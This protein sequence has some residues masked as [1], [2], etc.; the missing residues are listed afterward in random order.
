M[1]Y[2]N[3]SPSQLEAKAEELLKNF[4]KERLVKTKPIDVYAVIENCL[5]VPYDWKYLTPDQ[6]VLGMTAFNA[7]YIWVWDKPYYKDGMKPYQLML[8]KGTIV[9]DST[10]TEGN[11]RGRE[12]FTVMHEVF[13]Q[14]LHKQ[15]FRREPPDYIHETTNVAVN[16]KKKLVT[17][18]DKIEYQAN[19]CAAAF[20]MP[21]DL[22]TS[23]FKQMYSGSERMYS[24]QPLA[25]RIISDM[26]EEF[27][28]SNTAM[29][30]RLQNLSL[31]E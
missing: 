9:I 10:L 1:I 18:L 22:I 12:N 17:T 24:I 31:I 4:D 16:G 15:C 2:Y 20:L 21:R 25:K 8:E 19:T 28:V 13:H 23:V 29:K 7:G 5:D 30:Y 3:Y 11:N 14:V 27:N 26:A 6:S